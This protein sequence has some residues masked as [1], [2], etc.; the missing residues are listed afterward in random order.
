[1]RKAIIFD[2]SDGT[3]LLLP[4]PDEISVENEERYVN[5]HPCYRSDEMYYMIVEGDTEVYK[6]STEETAHKENGIVCY[7]TRPVYELETT[8]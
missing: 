6:V 3:I 7:E 2:Y 1:M 4:I 5:E 8:I